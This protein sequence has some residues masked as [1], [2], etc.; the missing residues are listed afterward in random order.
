[1]AQ[2]DQASACVLKFLLP[3]LARWYLS[4]RRIIFV[5]AFLLPAGLMLTLDLPP[6]AEAATTVTEASVSLPAKG[7]E[8]FRTDPHARESQGNQISGVVR[9][10]FA[11]RRGSLWFG[12]QD[13]IGRHDGAS[14]TYFDIRDRFD[15]GLTV[16]AI[17][18]DGVG[19][20]WFGTTGGVIRYDGKSFTTYDSDDGLRSDDVW[21]LF[22]DRAGLLWIGTIAGVSTFDGSRFT[23]FE[24]PAGTPDP[25]KGVSSEQI[26]WCILEDRQSRLWFAGEGAVFV[27]DGDAVSRIHLMDA[28]T[29]TYAGGIAEDPSGVLWLTSSKGLLRC[30]G[31]AFARVELPEVLQEVGLGVPY[32]DSHGNLWFS[33]NGVGVCR[34][35]GTSVRIF[36][37]EDGM[38]SGAIHV[39]REDRQGRIWCSGWMGAFRLDGERFVN[40][41]RAG[42]W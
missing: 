30:D 8:E 9:D 18:E 38:T 24:L 15:Q 21:S 25:N 2:R 6:G 4:V 36:S 42:P 12:T 26:V 11:D 1:M 13:G 37:A 16:R 5:P 23:S 10:I 28:E 7:L 14:L 20:V 39:T 31:N 34:Y 41:T 27:Y 32:A 40:V 33:A 17:T 29:V 22:V 3:T 35:D 19:H